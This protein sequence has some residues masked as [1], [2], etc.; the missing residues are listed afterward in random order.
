MSN[1]KLTTHRNR[2]K[3]KWQENMKKCLVSQ[4]NANQYGA[5]FRETDKDEKVVI[6]VVLAKVR[7]NRNFH[8]RFVGVKTGTF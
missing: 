3:K 4:R 1:D 6:Y 7:E 2:K 5:S 8:T